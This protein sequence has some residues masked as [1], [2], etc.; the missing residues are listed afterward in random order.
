MNGGGYIR[1]A[2][3]GAT[4]GSTTDRN[5][6]S[7]SFAQYEWG[8]MLMDSLP[9][10]LYKIARAAMETLPGLRP[11][12][13]TVRCGRTSGSQQVSFEAERAL[14]LTALQPMMNALGLGHQH[15]GL[16]SALGF[17]LGA[18]FTLPPN[19]AMLTFRPTRAGVE[20]RIDVDLD[21]LPDPPA[22]LMAL[23]RLQMTERPKS[24][25]GL[26]RWLL[27]L[28]PD[29]LPGPGSVSVLSAW[30]RPDLPARLALYL[31]PAALDP[32][33]APARKR[34]AATGQSL[35]DPAYD[36]QEWSSSAWSPVGA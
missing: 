4:F 15:A 34:E 17:I 30:T 1:S 5:G 2:N 9:S 12:F 18:R 33:A 36:E 16:M 22:Q 29:G 13:S 24:V 7:E 25:N 23:M 6:L 8:P 27:A 31:R 10:P 35:A 3:Y 20:F 19:T 21:S 28:T 32:E 26:D 11:A 14:P